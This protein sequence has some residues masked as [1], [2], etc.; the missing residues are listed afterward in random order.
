MFILYVID[1]SF[2]E[3]LDDFVLTP[4]KRLCSEKPIIEI[5]VSYGRIQYKFL[6]KNKNDAIAYKTAS[7]LTFY[8]IEDNPL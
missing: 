3:I 4:W 1:S 7:R 6:F 8:N 5:E 2:E